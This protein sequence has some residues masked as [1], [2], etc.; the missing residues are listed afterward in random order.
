MLF[1]GLRTR[2]KSW[3]AFRETDFIAVWILLIIKL[4][5]GVVLYFVHW[6]SFDFGIRFFAISSKIVQQSSTST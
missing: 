5:N 1:M 2:I 4:W 6:E 3:S